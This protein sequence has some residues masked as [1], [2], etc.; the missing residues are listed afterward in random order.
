M[1]LTMEVLFEVGGSEEVRLPPSFA[2]TYAIRP[3]GAPSPRRALSNPAEPR[4][5][6][7]DLS[8][9]RLGNAGHSGGTSWS[10]ETGVSGRRVV[11]EDLSDASGLLEGGEVPGVRK[12]DRSGA[13]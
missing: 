8:P 4:T 3:L 1:T 9:N 5:C 12:R 13:S 2:R 6:P 7:Q 11:E 10:V